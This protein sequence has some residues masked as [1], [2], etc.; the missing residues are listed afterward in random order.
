MLV[1]SWTEETQLSTILI[2]VDKDTYLNILYS[3]PYGW[4]CRYGDSSNWPVINCWRNKNGGSP[5]LTLAMHYQ[6]FRML[7]RMFRKK[8]H[9]QQ[10]IMAIWKMSDKQNHTNVDV[11]DG[12]GNPIGNLYFDGRGCTF[13]SILNCITSFGH[14]HT[15]C[16]LEYQH[17][18]N[19]QAVGKC[20]K[21]N[22]ITASLTNC[23]TRRNKEHISMIYN[24]C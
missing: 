13:K 23:K 6:S 9:D 10:P 21:W 19:H 4:M 24:S 16:S 12:S 5:L 3:Q 18:L 2:N 1:F 17:P 20:W 15:L 22:Q 8:P 7:Q 11:L 14:K